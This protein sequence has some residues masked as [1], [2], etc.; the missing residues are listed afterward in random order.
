MPLEDLTITTEV[1]TTTGSVSNPQGGVGGTLGGLDSKDG[2]DGSNDQVTFYSSMT[3]IFNDVS[4]TNI[5]TRQ[6]F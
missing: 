2:G 6:F 1:E 3:H 5:V 4:N